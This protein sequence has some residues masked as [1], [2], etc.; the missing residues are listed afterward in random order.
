M[1]YIVQSTTAELTLLQ[2]M[3]IDYLL[4]THAKKSKLCCIIHDAIVIDFS[5]Q[6]EHLLPAIK[7]LMSSTKFGNFKINISSGNNLGNLRELPV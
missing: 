6:D 1:N 2:A 3:K 4:R 7:S 5:S